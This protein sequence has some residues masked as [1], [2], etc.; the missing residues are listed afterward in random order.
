MTSAAQLWQDRFDDLLYKHL[1][2]NV[3]DD[4]TFAL[5]VDM[6]AL[7]RAEANRCG[8]PGYPE[9]LVRCVMAPPKETGSTPNQV[10]VEPAVLISALAQ[11]A[12]R[13][14]SKPGRRR[15]G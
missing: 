3:V 6:D 7:L 11:T 9:L 8:L 4:L 15:S 2:E 13:P 12:A 14:P 5:N 10:G 1:T